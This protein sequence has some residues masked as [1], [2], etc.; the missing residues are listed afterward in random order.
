MAFTAQ[1]EEG[2]SMQMVIENLQDPAG[3]LG[4]RRVFNVPTTVGVPAGVIDGSGWHAY[5]ALY[6]ADTLLALKDNML[7]DEDRDVALAGGVARLNASIGWQRLADP[8]EAEGLLN[9]ARDSDMPR[10][11]LL[12]SVMPDQD[13]EGFSAWFTQF[14]KSDIA[15][16][17]SLLP[18]CKLYGREPFFQRNLQAVWAAGWLP[19]V[20]STEPDSIARSAVEAGRAIV[21]RHVVSA[22][23]FDKIAAGVASAVSVDATAQTQT[24]EGAAEVMGD[25]AIWRVCPPHYL[26]PVDEAR[27]KAMVVR[28]TISDDLTREAC[29]ARFDEIDLIATDHVARGATTG[30]GLQ[31]QHHFL[32][33]L[34]DLARRLGCPP[35]DV[36]PKASS[37]PSTLFGHDAND[38]AVAL[39]APA[40][41]G[42]G[43]TPMPSLPG[44]QAE[45]D[46]F[47][48]D[49]FPHRVVA[50]VRGETLWP[51]RYMP[52]YL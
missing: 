4:D 21:F 6:D 49:S 51:T 32:P 9:M 36:I 33:A 18:C 43:V 26:L 47:A 40:R 25:A 3:L 2:M 48:P 44:I 45:R 22:G 38:W 13:T 29:L 7:A 52:Q 11:R 24:R 46:P 35:D 41:I 23:D 31:S 37:R 14:A 39:V 50:I 20:F 15:R 12:L 19:I 8:M 5:P 1:S 34:L 16:S 30:P 42:G 10:V 28:P 27:R 17:E